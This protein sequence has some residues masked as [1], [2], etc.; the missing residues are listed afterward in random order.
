MKVPG[1]KPASCRHARNLFASHT[2]QVA[3]CAHSC[4]NARREVAKGIKLGRVRTVIMAPSI[5]QIETE[6]GLDD[7]LSALLEQAQLAGVP[8]IFALSRK[9]L[10]Q[11]HAQ[12]KGVQ[13]CDRMLR[14]PWRLVQLASRST[15]QG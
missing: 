15:G 14:L 9:K 12:P 3:A 7:L 13:S 10:G 6:G 8:V 1:G 4:A 5:E 2:L 11:V